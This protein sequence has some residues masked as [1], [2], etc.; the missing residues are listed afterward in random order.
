MFGDLP[1]D[2]GHALPQLDDLELQGFVQQPDGS[3]AGTVA[4]QLGAS[5]SGLIPR[6]KQYATIT[7]ENGPWSATLG[8]LHQNGYT[9]VGDADIFT[10]E[11]E[12]RRVGTLSQWDLS[13]T[14][15]GFKNL[16]LTAGIKNLLNDDP[17]FSVTYDTNTGA[18][19]SWEPR[20]AD[21]RG[22]A[23]TLRLEYKF[24]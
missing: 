14:Y 1:L 17:P 4:N 5:T 9:D 20:V 21:P 3:F 15:K 2:E 8:N 13:G 18:G 16:T 22:R 6:Y 23:Y 19:S 7:W 10:N 11:I 24:F 12:S